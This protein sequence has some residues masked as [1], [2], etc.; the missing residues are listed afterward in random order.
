MSD[1]RDQPQNKVYDNTP[2]TLRDQRQLLDEPYPPLSSS[3]HEIV[4][5]NQELEIEHEGSDD[6]LSS[7]TPLGGDMTMSTDRKEYEVAAEDNSSSEKADKPL[8]P[9]T[10]LNE[11]SCVGGQWLEV[12]ENGGPE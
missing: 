7:A 3:H 5:G 2:L 12:N 4:L 9:S 8:L 6:P 10:S 1:V 11:D